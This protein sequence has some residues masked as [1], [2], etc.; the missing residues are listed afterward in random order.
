MLSKFGMLI[1][2]DLLKRVPSLKSKPGVDL[3]LY[4]HHIKNRH[5][6]TTPPWVV[7]FRWYLV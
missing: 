2:F 5:D 3:L 7:R 4:S 1:D 6:V